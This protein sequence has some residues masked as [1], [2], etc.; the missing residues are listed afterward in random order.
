VIP[1]VAFWHT[2]NVAPRSDR[3]NRL[4]LFFNATLGQY[5]EFRVDER[6]SADLG[7]L[8]RLEPDSDDLKGTSTEPFYF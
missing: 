4:L 3:C 8:T 1:V 2:A 6:R 7:S 5:Q